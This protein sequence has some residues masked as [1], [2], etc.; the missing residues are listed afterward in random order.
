VKLSV[1]LPDEDV[2][3]LDEYASEIDADSRS[4]VIQYSIKL[5]RHHRLMAQYAEAMDE[6]EASEDAALW[7]ALTGEG[8]EP[9]QP[10][11]DEPATESPE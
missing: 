3:F 6:W 10:W 9:E 7:D 8:L 5:L 1:S 11:W 2:A 4:A